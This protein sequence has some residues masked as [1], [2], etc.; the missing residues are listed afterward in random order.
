MILSGG[1]LD[2]DAKNC[3]GVTKKGMPRHFPVHRASLY[4]KFML[5]SAL[6]SGLVVELDIKYIY[7]YTYYTMFPLPDKRYTFSMSLLR[8]HPKTLCYLNLTDNQKCRSPWNHNNHNISLRQ[9]RWFT[10]LKAVK[11][12]NTQW[13]S[14]HFRNLFLRDTYHIYIYILI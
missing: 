14:G 6:W 10:N 2:G 9:V 1:F 11:I 12:S 4:R 8:S 5:F 7:I 3:T 13:W